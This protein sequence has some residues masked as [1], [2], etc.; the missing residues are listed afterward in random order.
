MTFLKYLISV[1]FFL[2][3]FSGLVFGKDQWFHSSGNYEGQRY[4]NLNQITKKNISNLNKVWTFNSGKTD[5]KNVVQATP[6]FIDDKLIV[7]DIFGGVY[8]LN[9]KNG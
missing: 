8:A 7:V 2:I 3:L 1:N 9:P 5:K 4:S 6:I